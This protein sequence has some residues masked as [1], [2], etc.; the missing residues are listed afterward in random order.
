MLLKYI[1]KLPSTPK[2]ED[3]I[4]NFDIPRISTELLDFLGC[5]FPDGNKEK[6]HVG[7]NATKYLMRSY[8]HNESFHTMKD[9]AP[10]TPGMMYCKLLKT[11]R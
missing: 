2:V 9:T 11:W 10:K 3:L 5:I 6:V 1:D 8:E 4:G 7:L